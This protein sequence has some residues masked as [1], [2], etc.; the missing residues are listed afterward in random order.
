MDIKLYSYL[1]GLFGTD[2]NVRRTQDNN[3][4]YDLT[5][6]LIDKD[7]IDK[8]Y[9]ALPDCSIS[10]RTRNTNFKNNYHSYILHCHNKEFI[11]W[12][13][14]NGFPLKDKTNLIA[15]PSGE[16]SESDFWRGV[17]DGD[18]SIGMKKNIAMPF[19]SLTTASEQLKEAYSNYIYKLTNF[20]PNN[21]RNQRDNIYNIT[22]HAEK[23]MIISNS[24]YYNANIYIDRKYQKYLENC[25]WKR[26]NTTNKYHYKWSQEELND[27]RILSID[28]FIQKY[29]ARTRAAVI[30]KRSKLKKIE[31]EVMINGNK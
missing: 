14:K 2:G 9:A 8:I 26:E 7:I 3:H 17:I 31:K 22:T 30:S 12:C 23:A 18:G 13:E 25:L 1:F 15:P 24:L 21:K 20:K 5:L 4:I 11:N 19:I 6:E 10:E 16:Y 29:P 28:K 27:L